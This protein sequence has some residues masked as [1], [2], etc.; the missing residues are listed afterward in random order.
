MSGV[1]DIKH[2][3]CQPC[4]P[5]SSKPSYFEPGIHPPFSTYPELESLNS[6]CQ[7]SICSSPRTLSP[8][9]TP[10]SSFR[11]RVQNP[12]PQATFKPEHHGHLKKTVFY[13][14]VT[15]KVYHGP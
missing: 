3:L 5:Y 2:L 14:K 1:M 12:L 15:N 8:P 4:E 11:R 10:P 9:Q 6:S 7:S 13:S